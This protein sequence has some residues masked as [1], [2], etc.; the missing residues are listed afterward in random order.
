MEVHDVY[1]ASIC[2]ADD[3][4]S[5]GAEVGVEVGAEVGNGRYTGCSARLKRD[6]GEQSNTVEGRLLV[7]EER[8]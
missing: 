8:P 5:V 6:S 1:D 3:E 2:A 7:A 4:V